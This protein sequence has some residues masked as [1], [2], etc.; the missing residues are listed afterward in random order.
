MGKKWSFKFDSKQ[1]SILLILVGIGLLFEIIGWFTV[2]QSFLLNPHRLFLMI[3]QIAVIG[4][5]ALGVTHVIIAGGID[6]S[7]GSIVALVAVVAASF[8]QAHNATRP[9]FQGLVGL[10]V[11]VPVLAGLS[12]GT[13]CGFINGFLVAKTN[14]PP[15]IATLGMM[16]SARGLAQ[17]YTSGKPVSMLS[18]SYT[19]LGTGFV[20]VII[21]LLMAV[22]AHV[23][24]KHTRYGKY[25]YAIGGNET[26]AKISGISTT[27]YK[28]MIYTFAGFLA[29][30]A[31]VVL[32][33]RVNSGQASMGVMFELDAIASAVIGGTSLSGG[34]G[35]IPGTIIGSMVL[36]V[37]KSGFTFLRVDAYI[38]EIIKG[39]IIICA[40][41]M[42]VMRN[43]KAA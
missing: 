17:F 19:F 6:L 40:V 23:S 16:V 14:I 33:A 32:S 13:L 38:Q 31:G 9:V 24:L 10:P 43:K 18:E 39:M 12:L 5:I 3:L 30:L 8:A 22:V 11:I 26:A 41:V 28:I 4:I 15:F 25:T 35:Y 20:P 42:D 7:S 29:G 27:R 1:L 21:Y 34:I 36:G 37:V 2:G